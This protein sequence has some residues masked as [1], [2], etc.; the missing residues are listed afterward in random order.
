MGAQAVG[1]V[2]LRP[3]QSGC[4]NCSAIARPWLEDG[5]QLSDVLQPAD[6]EEPSQVPLRSWRDLDGFCAK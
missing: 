6:P 1:P 5:P 3:T 4:L 2:E